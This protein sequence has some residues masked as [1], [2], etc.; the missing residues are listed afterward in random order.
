MALVKEGVGADISSLLFQRHLSPRKPTL[1]INLPSL[2]F[3]RY[4][5]GPLSQSQEGQGSHRKMGRVGPSWIQ[6][7]VQSHHVIGISLKV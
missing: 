1:Q 6:I 3:L 4:K 2:T 5:D 7:A